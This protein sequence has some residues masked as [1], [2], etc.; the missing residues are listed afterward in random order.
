VRA[1]HSPLCRA[2]HSLRYIP[3]PSSAPFT[4]GVPHKVRPSWA[5]LIW[6]RYSAPACCR[7][8]VLCSSP[9]LPWTWDGSSSC[10]Q[11][12]FI[13]IRHFG[14]LVNHQAAIHSILFRKLW[15]SGNSEHIHRWDEATGVASESTEQLSATHTARKDRSPLPSRHSAHSALFNFEFPIGTC[16]CLQQV[17]SSLQTHLR[18]GQSRIQVACRPQ[19]NPEY[20]PRLQSQAGP[21]KPNQLTR[22]G[23]L[24][25]TADLSQ[26]NYSP[27]PYAT[28]T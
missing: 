20:R 17:S 15:V 9:G 6:P 10:A 3:G 26:G 1:P 13:W 19:G 16:R 18:P 12:P 2:A 28:A 25:A 23:T 14:A 24:L 22:P 8:P 4:G 5:S 11:V 27:Y 21:Q 7:H